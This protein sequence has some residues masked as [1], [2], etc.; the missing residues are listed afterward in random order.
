M[1]KISSAYILLIAGIFSLC[2]FSFQFYKRIKLLMYS[3]E[4]VNRSTQVSFQVEKFFIGL[5]DATVDYRDYLRTH[6]KISLNDFNKKIKEYPGILNSLNQLEANNPEQLRR[7]QHLNVLAQQYVDY[8]LKLIE[9][10]KTYPPT[11]EMFNSARYM[12]DNI[13]VEVDNVS[14]TESK[15]MKERDDELHHHIFTTPL[16]L[17]IFSLTSIAII[18]YAFLSIIKQI[19]RTQALE[20]VEESE[21]RFRALIE[22]S[23]DVVTL[24][25]T[26]GLFV[27]LSASIKN[28]FGYDESELIG[29][30]VLEFVHPDDI[31]MLVK[32]SKPLIEE[33]RTVT[34]IVR[35][36]HKSGNWIWV[37]STIAN[38]LDVPY[39]NAYVS[40]MHDITEQKLIQDTLKRS[41]ENF[42][43][44]ADLVP[45]IIWTARTD[46]YFDYYNKRWYEYTGFEEGF[47]DQ[48]WIPILHPDDVQVCIDTWY[49]SVKTGE[50]YQIEYRFKDKNKPG[51]YRWFLG[52]AL[53]IKNEEGIVIKWFGTCTDIQDQKTIRENLEQLVKERAAELTAKNRDLNEAQRIAHIG[54]WEWDINENKIFW[55][56]ELYRIFG[57]VPEGF[58]TTYENYI[59]LIRPDDRGHVKAVIQEALSLRRSFDFYHRVKRHDGVVRIVHGRGQVH[60]NKSG[61]PVRITGTAQD[62]TEMVEIQNKINE[63]N[64]TFNFAEQTS[65]T[66]SF[67]YNFSTGIFMYSDN[68]Y[69]LLGCKPGEFEPT[70]EN[71]TRFVHPEDL[72]HILSEN[73]GL[74]EENI[75]NEYLFRV[76]KKDGS[77]INV[78]NTG[79]FITEENERIYIGTLQ[80]ITVQHNKEIQLLEQNTTLEKMNRE[81]A[82]FSY[83]ASHDLQE[84][85][86]KIR[87][88]TRRIMEKEIDILSDNAKD[89]FTRIENA[90]TR[91]QQLIDDLLNYSRT[92]TAQVHFESTDLDELL[93]DVSESLKEKITQTNAVIESSGLQTANVI[94]FQFQ[95]LLTNLFTNSMKF[96]RPGVPPHIRISHNVINGERAKEIPALRK[97]KYH[98]YTIKDNGIGFEPQ[99]NEQ[100]FGLFQRLHGRNEF[101]GTGI[102]LAICKKIVENHNGII[103][104]NGTIDQ[105]ATFDIYIPVEQK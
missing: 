65:L 45:Q 97:T 95:Q 67:R 72:H 40:N 69:R 59:S 9:I 71:F 86:R 32:N 105:G 22:N 1:K 70:F 35:F 30:N 82:S 80:D 51:S 81:L 3:Y 14:N 26:N 41:E 31:E 17:L 85:L 38:L 102:G 46:G 90:A 19:K 88:F 54:S 48:S 62:I 60:T 36:L 53:P 64:Q 10:D 43:Q 79:I 93:E 47:G 50:P 91:M 25:D 73:Q 96:T 75:S 7:L 76:I 2:I 33:K 92:N 74:N 5:R 100:I 103:T 15:I 83:V 68:L 13:R 16:F 27:Y 37:E 57:I 63:L 98:H 23:I 84:P 66:G 20:K 8:S 89:Y 21:K 101:E 99:Y 77:I 24:T 11:E 56:D 94:P 55:S 29:K 104:A 6:N 49:H 4:M 18:T 78:R 12:L 87:M 61:E 39:I 52:K 58:E 28:V 42:R 34:N 44:L